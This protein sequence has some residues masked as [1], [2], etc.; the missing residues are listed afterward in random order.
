MERE[1]ILRIKYLVP[2]VYRGYEC[3]YDEYYPINLKDAIRLICGKEIYDDL[4]DCMV[5]LSQNEIPVELDGEPIKIISYENHEYWV[6]ISST[7]FVYN[8]ETDKLKI[9]IEEK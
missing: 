6:A 7:I 2:K 5:K 4:W 9:L 8:E 1:I 3:Q